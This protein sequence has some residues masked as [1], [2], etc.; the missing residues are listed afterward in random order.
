MAES[1]RA[2]KTLKNNCERLMMML[3]TKCIE[4]NVF[5][6]YL[7][8]CIFTKGFSLKENTTTRKKL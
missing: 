4:R 8:W 3:L 5:R 1:L 2:Q 7:I 6:L